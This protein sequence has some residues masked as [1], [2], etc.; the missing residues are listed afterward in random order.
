MQGLCHGEQLRKSPFKEYFR[1][2]KSDR[3]CILML[4]SQENKNTLQKLPYDTYKKTLLAPSLIYLLTE[5][6]YCA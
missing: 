3:Y 6:I 2:L 1:I 5:M 4:L